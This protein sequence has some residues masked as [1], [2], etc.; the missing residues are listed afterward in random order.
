MAISS[1]YNQIFHPIIVTMF[2][3]DLYDRIYLKCDLILI[4]KTDNEYEIKMHRKLYL[5][6][7]I[8]FTDLYTH[9]HVYQSQKIPTEQEMV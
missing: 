3:I 8:G 6:V 7:P 1:L 5:I 9:K 4:N 2:V